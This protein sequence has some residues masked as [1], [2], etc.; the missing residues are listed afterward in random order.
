MGRAFFVQNAQSIIGYRVSK[1]T[2]LRNGP[3]V[4]RSNTPAFHA[5]DA[6]SNPAGV[7]K[8][9]GIPELAKGGRL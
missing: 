2:L 9:G 4:K 7:T 1:K 3:I 8:H 6:G 5:G